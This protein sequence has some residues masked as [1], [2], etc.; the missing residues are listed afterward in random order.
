[1]TKE[2]KNAVSRLRKLQDAAF[3]G[4]IDYP[5]VQISL[6]FYNH[7]YES[8]DY[9][10]VDVSICVHNEFSEMQKHM[11]YTLS[12]KQCYQVGN[13]DNQDLSIADILHEI[14]VTVDYPV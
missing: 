5:A 3:A 6:S 11:M 13:A 8:G 10:S 4:K 14:A 7:H 9:A 12:D 1:M 2:L